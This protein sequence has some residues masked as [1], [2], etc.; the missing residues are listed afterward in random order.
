[1]NYFFLFQQVQE[2][3]PL[4]QFYITVKD[5]GG[6]FM[7]RINKM[8]ELTLFAPSNH[9]WKDPNLRGLIQDKNRMREILNMHVVEEKL[10]LEKIIEKNV[11]QVI[12]L[13]ADYYCLK[14]ILVGETFLIFV[15]M[16]YFVEI[17]INPVNL[18]VPT[19]ILGRIKIITSL[20]FKCT[21]ISLFRFHIQNNYLF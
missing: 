8:K 12:Y 17:I 18:A 5:H 9:A 14:L 16:L 19:P 6:D 2:D 13:K 11:N 15:R 21:L 4:Y 1:M 3:G 20:N 10:S 7:D